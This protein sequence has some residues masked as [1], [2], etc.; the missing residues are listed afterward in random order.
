M[1]DLEDLRNILGQIYWPHPR[2]CRLSPDSGS[3]LCNS[4][5]GKLRASKPSTASPGSNLPHNEIRVT[6][7]NLK[8]LTMTPVAFTTQG[9]VY[10]PGGDLPPFSFS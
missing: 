7:P 5:I 2:R 8:V 9:S 1:T 3:R 4:Q 6:F 10:V